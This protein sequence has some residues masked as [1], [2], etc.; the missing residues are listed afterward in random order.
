MVGSSIARK[1]RDEKIEVFGKSSKE[2]DF[3]NREET[4]KE[5]KNISPDVLI[6]AAAKVG[7]IG[8]NSTYPVEFLTINLQLQTNLLD[9]AHAADI[10]KVIFLGS[11]CIY[12]KFAA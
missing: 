11:S 12:P 3:T 9:A 2:L 8:A 4:F 7:G 10:K 5:L 1:F 6:I